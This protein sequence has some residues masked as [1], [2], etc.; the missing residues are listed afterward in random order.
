MPS[1]LQ[2]L[3]DALIAV[4]ASRRK[5]VVPEGD[6]HVSVRRALC[7][8]LP[9]WPIGFLIFAVLGTI[10]MGLATPTEA[11]G[12]GVTAELAQRTYS[13]WVGDGSERDGDAEWPALLRRARRL[14]PG[15]ED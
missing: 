14:S 2:P 9:I 5:S 3:S 6:E 11:A 13:Q 15:F 8:L 4:M 1:E 10:Y 7:E 12:L